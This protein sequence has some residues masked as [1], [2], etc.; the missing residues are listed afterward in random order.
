MS[1]GPWRVPIT[2]LRRSLGARQPVRREGSLGRLV[3]ADTVVAPDAIVA[4]DV[5]LC[6]VDGGVE[7]SG[8]VT[9]PFRGTCRRC[10]QPLAGEVVAEVRELY[11]PIGARRRDGDDDEDTYELGI[12]HLDLEPMARDAVLLELPLAPLCRADCAGLCV[13]C[14]ADRNVEAC[15][16]APE[17]IDDRW[18]ALDVLRESP[19]P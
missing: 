3:V 5:V 18:A 2:T 14:G 8:G 10:Q 12:D 16:C 13:R 1:P 7:V 11:R 6:A 15:G 19:S 9:A 17:P 4:A